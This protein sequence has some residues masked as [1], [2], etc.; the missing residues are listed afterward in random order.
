MP[1]AAHAP[2]GFFHGAGEKKPTASGGQIPIPVKKLEETDA[3]C[4]IAA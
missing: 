1:P 2:G 3:S 4:C